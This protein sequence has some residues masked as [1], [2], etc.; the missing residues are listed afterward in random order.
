MDQA[1][2]VGEVVLTVTADYQSDAGSVVSSL[3]YCFGD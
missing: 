1:T 3:W 2:E